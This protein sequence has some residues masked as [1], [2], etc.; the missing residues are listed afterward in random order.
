MKTASDHSAFP[1]RRAA[2]YAQDDGVLVAP[3][4]N[5]HI[6]QC[7]RNLFSNIWIKSIE[8]VLF[9]EKTSTVSPNICDDKR[10]FAKY[11]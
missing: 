10:G 8:G 6:L 11:S 7:H 4:A 1:P 3:R 2:P 5:E 9:T